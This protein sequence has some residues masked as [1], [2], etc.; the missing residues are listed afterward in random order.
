MNETVKIW[1]DISL[2]DLNSSRLLYEN[3][4]YRTS[5]FLFQQATEKA[6]KAFAHLAGLFSETEFKDIQHDQMKIY[7]KSIIKQER[8]IDT[9]IQLFEPYPKIANHKIFEKTNFTEYQKSLLNGVSFIDSLRNNDLVR[10]SA[11]DLNSII[12]QLIKLRDT[13]IKIPRNFDFLFKTKILEVTDWIGQLGTEKAIE[14]KEK[15]EKLINDQEQS[16]QLYD[17]MVT[18]VFPLLIDLV[19]VNVTLYVCALI[20]IQHS[21]LTRYPEYNINPDSIYIK[22]LPVVKKQNEFMDLLNEATLKINRINQNTN[23]KNA[24]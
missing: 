17:L 3:G 7:R 24:C 14:E 1:T 6:N 8:I 21:S 23:E 13:Q 19:F 5:Y 2:S 15:L 9:L 12:K 10:I 16:S 4:H 11:Y 18:Q 20:T 22:R